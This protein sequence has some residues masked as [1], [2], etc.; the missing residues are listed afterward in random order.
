M[1]LCILT[2][3]MPAEKTITFTEARVDPV[4]DVAKK[5]NALIQS[6]RDFVK[7]LMAENA[8]HEGLLQEKYMPWDFEDCTQKSPVKEGILGQGASEANGVGTLKEDGIRSHGKQ[9]RM[10]RPLIS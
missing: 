6:G 8:E 10:I 7:K 3:P 1:F 9:R 2:L 4:N 5:I